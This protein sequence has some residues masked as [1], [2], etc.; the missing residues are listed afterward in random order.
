M[1]AQKNRIALMKT[2]KS[3]T[4]LAKDLQN[5]FGGKVNSLRT[6]V[7]NMIYCRNYYPRY[8]EYLN[9][10]YG[11]EFERPAHMRTA[12]QLLKAA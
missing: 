8:A 1:T 10:K 5:Q 3:M 6:M 9:N 2:G 12:R 4:D 11:F 7:E